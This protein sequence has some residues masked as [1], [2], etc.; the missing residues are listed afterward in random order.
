MSGIEASLPTLVPTLFN[1]Y[2]PRLA[3]EADERQ[4]AEVKPQAQ[5]SS[6]CEP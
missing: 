4:N 5:Y 1:A 6:A 3:E 2:F